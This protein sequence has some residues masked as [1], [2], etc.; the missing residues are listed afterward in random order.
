MHPFENRSTV[1]ARGDDTCGFTVI[2]TEPFDLTP[3]Y[4]PALFGWMRVVK[5]RGGGGG[6]ELDGR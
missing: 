4:I 5:R 3:G 2:Y 1:V 6:V